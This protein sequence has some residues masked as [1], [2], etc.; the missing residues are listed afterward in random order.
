LYLE[1]IEVFDGVG[2]VD[3]SH[4]ITVTRD[5]S[6]KRDGLQQQFQADKIILATGSVP[7]IPP[8]PE[9]VGQ[10]RGW[11]NKLYIVVLAASL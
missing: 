4:T 10:E 8:F 2:T 1:R 9:L 11:G 7:L 6:S 5:E 3:A